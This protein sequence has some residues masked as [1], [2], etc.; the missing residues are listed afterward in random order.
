MTAV[1]YLLAFGTAPL[2]LMAGVLK[3]RSA[4]QRPEEKRRLMRQ[5]MLYSL[6]ALAWLFVAFSLRG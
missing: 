6:A 2:F 3:F 5:G 1:R 4:L